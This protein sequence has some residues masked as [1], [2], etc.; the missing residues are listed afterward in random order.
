MAIEKYEG[1]SGGGLG[2]LLGV[3]MGAARAIA[4]DPTGIAQAVGSLGTEDSPAAKLGGMASQLG[5]MGGQSGAI[6]NKLSVGLP[7]L[8]GGM[9]F[10][11]W[12]QQQS[13]DANPTGSFGAIGRRLKQQ[14]FG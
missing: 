7:G 1:K 8:Q 10:N 11:E 5:S 14:T 3:G 9:P 13:D 12:Q 4:G 6:K 2:K